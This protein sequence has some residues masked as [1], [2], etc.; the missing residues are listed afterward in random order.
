MPALFHRSRHFWLALALIAALGFALRVAGAQGALWLDE[1]W[2]AVM[3]RDVGTPLGVFLS[4]NHD[5]NHHLNSLWLQLVG[6]GAPPPWARAPAIVASTISIVVA[7]LIAAR[8]GTGAALVTALLFALSPMLVTLGSEARGYAPMVLALLVAVWLVDRWLAGDRDAERPVYLALCFGL[9]ALCQLT[10]VFGVVALV[11]WSF[12]TL[13]RRNGFRRAA[14]DTLR[15]FGTALIALAIVL[16]IVANAAWLSGSGFRFGTYAPFTT[17]DFLTGVTAAIGYTIGFPIQSAWLIALPLGLL[18]LARGGSRLPFYL[19]AI[20]AFPLMLAILHAG[21]TGYSRYYLLVTVAL[22][23]LLGEII[24]NARGWTRWIAGGALVAIVVGSLAQ[25]VDLARNRRGDPG[26]AIRIIAA[27]APGGATIGFDA[28]SGGAVIEAAAAT[29]RYPATIVSEDC[30]APRFLYI[31]RF[32][33]E[34]FP[35]TFTRCHTSYRLIAAARTTGLSGT[36]W[37]LYERLPGAR[38]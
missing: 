36:H 11:G 34:A 16:A 4:I 23:L 10:I 7:A 22:L 3:A 2:S 33:G 14:I 28:A 38:P 20:I 30:P 35:A 5:N 8:R 6:F 26:A 27:R 25:D 15:Y 18:A 29:A 12:L 24:G 37:T 21:N 17:T 31:A 1:A 19:L 9:G 32:G 13:W